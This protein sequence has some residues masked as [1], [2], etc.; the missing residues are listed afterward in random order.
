MLQKVRA[1]GA[2]VAV[3][4]ADLDTVLV[5]QVLGSALAAEEWAVV[6]ARAVEQAAPAD[7]HRAGLAVR[8]SGNPAV[9]AAVVLVVERG[10]AEEV[11]VA[12][13][14]RAGEPGQAVEAV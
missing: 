2:A 10:P 13:Q 8:A 12:V 7:P 14:V 3:G 6:V 5:E 11:L 4:Q 1:P 9:V